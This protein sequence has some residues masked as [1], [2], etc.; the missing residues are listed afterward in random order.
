[1]MAYK[2]A[3]LLF[4]LYNSKIPSLEWMYLNFQQTLTSRQSLFKTMKNNKLRVG[5][6]ALAN[7]L[8]LVNNKIPLN[9]LNLSVNSFKINCKKIFL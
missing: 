7:R 3:L 1:M 4:K 6:N 2:H 9:W 5:N 8:T